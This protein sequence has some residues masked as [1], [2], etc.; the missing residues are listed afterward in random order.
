MKKD[1]PVAIERCHALLEWLIPALDQLPRTR[2][3][4]LGQRIELSAVD[5]LEQLIVAQY[6]PKHRGEALRIANAK[7]NL[8]IHLWRLLSNLRAIPFKR[9]AHGAELMVEVGRQI[10]GWSAR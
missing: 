4:G 1:T 10:G 9:Y 2:K 7:L 3:Y 8:V 5:V 6:Q